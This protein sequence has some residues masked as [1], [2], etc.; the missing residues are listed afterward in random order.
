MLYIF[1]NLNVPSAQ[2]VTLWLESSAISS[3]IVKLGRAKVVTYGNGNRNLVVAKV[4]TYGN[5]NF[6]WTKPCVGAAQNET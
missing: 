1:C 3:Q 6:A 2:V 4:V 5:G